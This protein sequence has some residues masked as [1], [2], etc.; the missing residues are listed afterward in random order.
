M[1]GIVRNN[2]IAICAD[3]GI[4]VIKNKDGKIYN[5]T[6][7]SNRFTPDVRVSA[8]NVKY[9]NNI[10]DRPLNLRDGTIVTQSNNLVLS[11]PSDGSL[12]V[13][14]PRY[15]FHLKTTAVLAIDRGYN[16]GSEVPIDFEGNPRPQGPAFDIGADE[17]VKY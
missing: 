6:L 13:D 11:W 7:Y 4:S 5:N 8:L 16:L 1:G 3:A 12:F 17:L 15:N 14:A 2:R 10:L 9:I